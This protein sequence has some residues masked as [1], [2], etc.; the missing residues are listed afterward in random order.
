[1][2]LPPALVAFFGLSSN[3]VLSLIGVAIGLDNRDDKT[4]TPSDDGQVEEFDFSLVGQKE[5]QAWELS[6]AG[7]L[8]GMIN[9]YLNPILNEAVVDL[10]AQN[11]GQHVLIK[12]AII[13]RQQ[14]FSTPNYPTIF[15]TTSVGT[16]NS[17]LPTTLLINL[18][19]TLIPPDKVLTYDIG[20]SEYERTNFVEV[21]AQ[22]LGVEGK[23]A[24]N[25]SDLNR[26]QFESGSISRFG[27][28][29][30]IFMGVDYGHVRGDIDATGIW[31]PFL[32]DWWFNKNRYA[33]GTVELIGLNQH[34]AVGE[35]IQLDEENI[36]CHVEG[37]THNFTVDREGNRIFRTT[38]EFDR[39]IK[40][41]SSSAQYFFI[42]GDAAFS[43]S[44]SLSN[45]AATHVP[46]DTSVFAQDVKSRVS[47]TPTSKPA[48]LSLGVGLT[49][50]L[51]S[52]GDAIKGK[53]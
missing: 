42:Y 4:F 8:W 27:L 18:P 23:S 32:M 24:G 53:F 20:Y 30:K 26:P 48:S 28:R 34:I 38:I 19:T 41:D 21:N 33:S 13:V 16:S 25:F 9:Q 40:A 22:D 7:T 1:M 14:P 52:L 17:P 46:P 6:T 51:K 39:G 31:T 2:I 11:V 50:A 47:F 49:D 44:A 15:K 36:L 43:Q 3:E 5:F 10:Q 45:F 29:P 12:P 35:N 37:Y